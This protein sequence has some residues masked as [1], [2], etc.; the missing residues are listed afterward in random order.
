MDV[1]DYVATKIM[2]KTFVGYK[3]SRF[4]FAGKLDGK[5]QA[6]EDSKLRYIIGS[7]LI[8]EQWFHPYYAFL[9]KICC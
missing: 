7:K 8:N 2:K 3:F 9:L 6:H 4:D 5:I 1:S